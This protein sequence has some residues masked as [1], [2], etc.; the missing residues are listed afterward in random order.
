MTLTT[1]T[2]RIRFSEC[3][4]RRNGVLP[5]GLR[6]VQR[7]AGRVG[8]L[9]H[10]YTYLLIAISLAVECVAIGLY[11]L[12]IVHDPKSQGHDRLGKR[13]S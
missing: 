9:L 5:A 10:Y 13:L 1:L 12:H 11:G 6:D 2:H 3:E 7:S 8:R 4:P